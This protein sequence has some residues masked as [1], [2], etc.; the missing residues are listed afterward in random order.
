MPPDLLEG[1]NRFLL[2]LAGLVIVSVASSAP[3]AGE[4]AATLFLMRVDTRLGLAV[5]SPFT[6]LD[7]GDMMMVVKSYKVKYL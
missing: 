1:G 4:F 3:A 6:S 2:R 7:G 5:A